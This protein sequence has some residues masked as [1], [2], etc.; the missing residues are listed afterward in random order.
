MSYDFVIVGAG[1]AGSVI[2]KRL[3]DQNYTVCLLEAGRDDAK[4]KPILPEAST[5]PVPQPGD[6]DWGQFIK[7]PELGSILYSRGF[8]DWWFFQK[9]S[10]DPKSRSITYN[11][12]STWGGCSS[13][14]S[15]VSVRNAKYNWDKWSNMGFNSF[16]YDNML[17]FYKKVE[18]R[19]QLRNNFTP[20]YDPNVENGKLGSIHV[21]YGF[22]GMVP[23]LYY[24]IN[25]SSK[26]VT[27]MQQIVSDFGYP[28]YLVDLDNPDYAY[29]GG[30]SA[31][32]YSIV[33]THGYILKPNTETFVPYSQ[34]NPYQERNNNY[35]YQR[36]SSANTY[37]YASNFRNLEIKSEVLVTE[38]ITEVNNNILVAKGV[39][40][41]EGWNLYQ[42]GR[43]LY[44]CG[45][46]PRV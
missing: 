29:L 32:N 11:R 37:L 46:S 12:A 39:K 33:D 44:T 23:L 34:Y 20:Y 13:H 25:T 38:I 41:L 15:S 31:N 4:L 8:T 27:V 18:N 21:D 35:N 3:S 5:A 42:T 6:F 7:T 45:Q 36:A 43:E 17:P 1:H 26:F 2:A 22:N 14:N 10:D 28:N 40:Y 9:Q 19:S 16:S 24:D 30:L